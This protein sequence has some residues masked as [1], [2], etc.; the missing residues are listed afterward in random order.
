MNPL[1]LEP[2]GV[3]VIAPGKIGEHQLWLSLQQGSG[4]AKQGSPE[5]CAF[6]CGEDSG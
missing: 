2:H 5:I 3:T 1:L 4:C 6:E